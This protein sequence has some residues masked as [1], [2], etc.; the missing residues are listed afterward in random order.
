MGKQPSCRPGGTSGRIIPWGSD[1]HPANQRQVDGSIQP[2]LGYRTTSFGPEGLQHAVLGGSRTNKSVCPALG[3]VRMVLADRLG[4]EGI[5][6]QPPKLP[7]LVRLVRRPSRVS[8][9]SPFVAAV[10]GGIERTYGL[11]ERVVSGSAAMHQ[12]QQKLE[13]ERSI[14]ISLASMASSPRSTPA[15]LEGSS[16]LGEARVRL[17]VRRRRGAACWWRGARRDGAWVDDA[18]AGVHQRAMDHEGL[19][20][21]RLASLAFPLHPS[22]VPSQPY[23]RPVAAVGL[24][25]SWPPSR[26]AWNKVPRYAVPVS[27]WAGE[28]A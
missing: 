23:P 9:R 22:S 15:V 17:L 8:P 1:G 14:L 13:L 21:S 11:Q 10:K 16:D 18:P 19:C 27:S 20:N 26:A 12:Q 7:S 24:P 25:W 5:D 2:R 3:T 4:K 28:E 6:H